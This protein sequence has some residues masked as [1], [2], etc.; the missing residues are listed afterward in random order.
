MIG[1]ATLKLKSYTDGV[2]KL[3]IALANE[4]RARVEQRSL[5]LSSLD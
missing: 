3:G 2:E 4:D 1:T 5:N